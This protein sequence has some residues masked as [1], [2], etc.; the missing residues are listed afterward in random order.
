MLN[1]L[2][3]QYRRLHLRCTPY[4]CMKVVLYFCGDYPQYHPLSL[5]P[6]PLRNTVIDFWRL[7]WQE[8]CPSIVILTN[9]VEGGVVKCLQY[10]PD[11]D[12]KS[13]G[14]FKVTITDKQMFADYFIRVFQVEVSMVSKLTAYH[15]KYQSVAYRH[16]I[17]GNR[18]FD[19][20]I[21][22]RS[23]FE[24]TLSDH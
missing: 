7:V 15:I 20:R 19:H 10:W 8:K 23:L 4:F 17:I 18:Q 21:T 11:I 6:A 12:S 24:L 16:G 13:Y 1:I 5:S 22:K 14:P 9:L 2:I 3:F